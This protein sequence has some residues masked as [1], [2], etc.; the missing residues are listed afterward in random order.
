MGVSYSSGSW[1]GTDLLD[2]ERSPEMEALL[3]EDI[4]QWEPR[5]VGCGDLVH[6]LNFV[7]LKDYPNVAL[8]EIP[9]HYSRVRP[10]RLYLEHVGI[11]RAIEAWAKG[12]VVTLP[13]LESVRE[14]LRVV[15]DLLGLPFDVEAL[16]WRQQGYLS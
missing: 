14:E 15:A 4:R 7:A 2:F 10:D 6:D 8:G 3:S 12:E 11:K 1:F 13:D 16:R 9:E 5:D